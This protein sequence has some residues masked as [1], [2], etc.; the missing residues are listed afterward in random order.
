MYKNSYGNYTILQISE[1]IRN[2]SCKCSRLVESMNFSTL[3]SYN[4]RRA[5]YINFYLQY[6]N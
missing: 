1:I 3:S 6:K 5:S 2:I 4:T